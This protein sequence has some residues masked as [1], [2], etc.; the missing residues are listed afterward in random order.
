MC[1]M[2][3]IQPHLLGPVLPGLC[4][5]ISGKVC[6]RPP[7]RVLHEACSR[8]VHPHPAV[9]AIHTVSHKSGLTL[10]KQVPQTRRRA[11]LFFFSHARR[12]MSRSP[13]ALCPLRWRYSFR[14]GTDMSTYPFCCDTWFQCCR[15]RDCS[16]PFISSSRY[17]HVLPT[18]GSKERLVRSFAP[19]TM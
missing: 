10:C 7:C 17:A 2:Q 13:L 19:V 9:G 11:R 12:V 16:L 3:A 1:C 14:S 5:D 18:A 6:A 15:S 4:G 8:A